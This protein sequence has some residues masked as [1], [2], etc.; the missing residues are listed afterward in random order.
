MIVRKI[1]GYGQLYGLFMVW[2]FSGLYLG[3]VVYGVVLL[4]IFALW[5][6]QMHLE[7]FLG[8]WVILIMSDSLEPSMAW[9]KTLKNL[10]I[11]ILAAIMYV[12]REKFGETV[13]IHRYFIPFLVIA[14][15]ALIESP[16]AL[17]GVQRT[18]S[19]LLILV[20]APNFITKGYRDKGVDALVDM[21]YIAMG[22]LFFCLV[23]RFIDSEVAY[24]HGTRL[25]GIF[26]NPNGLG[27]YLIVCFILFETVNSLYKGTFSKAERW[28]FYLMV[29]ACVVMCSSRNAL[30][31]I[32]MFVILSRVVKVSATLGIVLA[33]I[34]LGLYE[35]VTINI[36]SIASSLGLEE[37]LRVD[38]I[39]EG[40]GR[41]IAWRFAWETIQDHFFLGRGFSYDLFLM[42]SNFDWLSRAGH[43]GGVHNSYLII[44]LNTGLI[45]LLLFFR[46]FFLMFIKA[47][48]V[49]R[50]AIPAMIAVMFSINFEPWLAAS[51]NPYTIVL[52]VIL[53]V[54]TEPVFR[55]EVEQ[56]D[57]EEEPSVTRP[58]LPFSYHGKKA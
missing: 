21:L 47:S 51:L 1:L 38:T 24:S 4:S 7:I 36:V 35:V 39:E 54:M 6:K 2:L 49:T 17:N 37:Y 9:A 30:V 44:W 13:K 31:S 41:I 29:A 46:G 16:V 3:P 33:I 42:R 14:C 26:G 5:R 23:W 32:T 28:I 52:L 45:G 25:R 58:K 15:V 10:Y 55:T 12:D 57:T 11:L 56:E 18:L 50:L 22:V 34:G 8:F 43:E 48:K 40:S 20:V 19:Y 53:T 27:L